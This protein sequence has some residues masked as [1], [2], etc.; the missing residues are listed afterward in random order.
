MNKKQKKV[1]YRILSAFIITV[2]IAF[3]KIDDKIKFVLFLLPYFIAGY[4]ILFDAFRGIINRQPFDENFLM[5][6]AT[7]GAFILG[8]YS[9]AVLVMMFYQLGELF[10]SYAVGKSRKNI[11]GLLDLRPDYANVM[12]E[13]RSV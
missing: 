4:D 9:E 6:I 13:S 12:K 5:M 2:L 3:L 8:E 11:T 1:L 10:Q 7:I